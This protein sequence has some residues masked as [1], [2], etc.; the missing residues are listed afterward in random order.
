MSIVAAAGAKVGASA[1]HAVMR[2]LSVLCVLLVFAGIGWAVYVTVVR[3][4][5][6]PNPTTTEY[7]DNIY[8]HEVSQ[9][10]VW[11]GCMSIQVRDELRKKQQAQNATVQD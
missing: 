9:P 3:P 4:H 11:F 8:K 1:A 6:K 7:A 5:T 10:R 2:T